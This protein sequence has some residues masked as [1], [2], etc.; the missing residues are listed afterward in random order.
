MAGRVGKKL[1]KLK[2]MRLTGDM[3]RRRL[4]KY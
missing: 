3:L 2:R 4:I 1:Q